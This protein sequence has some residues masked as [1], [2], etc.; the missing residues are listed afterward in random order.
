MKKK[1]DD[2]YYVVR[3]LKVKVF[4][5]K[6]WETF[7]GSNNYAIVKGYE[8]HHDIYGCPAGDHDDS[9]VWSFCKDIVPLVPGIEDLEPGECKRFQSITLFKKDGEQVKYD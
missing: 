2:V 3:G 5:H 9:L 1:K 6:K 8:F 4:Q 7:D